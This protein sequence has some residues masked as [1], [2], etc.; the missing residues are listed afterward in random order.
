MGPW[1]AFEV[2][3]VVGITPAAVEVAAGGADESGGKPG[4]HAL[5]LDGVEDFRSVVEFGELHGLKKSEG[6]KVGKS[7]SQNSRALF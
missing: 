2:P 4:G 5:T 6:L 1:G 3:G 7:K